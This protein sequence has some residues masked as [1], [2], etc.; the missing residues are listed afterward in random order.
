MSIDLNNLLGDVSQIT[1][2]YMVVPQNC[3]RYDILKNY[4][5]L[6]DRWVKLYDSIEEVHFRMANRKN[7]PNYTIEALTPE[8]AE[9]HNIPLAGFVAD[10]LEAEKAENKPTRK[11]N[12]KKDED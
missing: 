8:L 2:K 3:P 7:K 11:S 12:A 10:K 1:Y 4:S 5:C 6:D 9:K